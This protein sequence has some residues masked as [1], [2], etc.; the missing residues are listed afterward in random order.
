MRELGESSDALHA[1]LAPLILS[2]KVDTLVLVG[3]AMAPLAKALEGKVELS[4]V[5]NAAAA[6]A[7]AL[8]LI[9]PGC[10]LLV[11]G[12]NA[13]GLAKIVASLTNGQT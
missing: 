7:L 2:N 9:T 3:E 11:K 8:K 12:S 6:D 1:S 13:L 10:A 4:H 5:M